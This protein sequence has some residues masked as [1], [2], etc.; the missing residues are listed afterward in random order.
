MEFVKD[1]IKSK[2]I[3]ILMLV[4]AIVLF[5][6]GGVLGYLYYKKGKDYQNL[7]NEK[8]LLV[9][10]LQTSETDILAENQDL[11]AQVT[12]YQRKNALAKA[13]NDFLTYFVSVA[14]KHNGLNNWTNAEWDEGRRLAEATGNSSFVNLFDWARNNQSIS[15]ID[16]MIKM[17]DAIASGIGRNL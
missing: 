3:F 8:E 13:Y 5:L 6:T 11:K 16:R 14:Q 7:S 17:L 4:I 15:Q 10:Q 2:K 9:D 12:E 1:P